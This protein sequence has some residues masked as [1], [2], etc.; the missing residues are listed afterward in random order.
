MGMSAVA[1]KDAKPKRNIGSSHDNLFKREFHQSIIISYLLDV[2][3]EL[4]HDIMLQYCLA[5]PQLFLPA[6]A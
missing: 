6:E 2:E 3:A 5:F 4:H 1:T